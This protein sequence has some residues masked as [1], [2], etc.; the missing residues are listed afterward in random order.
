[1][2]RSRTVSEREPYRLPTQTA[3]PPRRS[4]N[5]REARLWLE[6]EVRKQL[7]IDAAA[8]LSRAIPI[9]LQERW[10]RHEASTP[11]AALSGSQLDELAREMADYHARHGTNQ[12]Y[13]DIE[14]EAKRRRGEAA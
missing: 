4:P 7:R 2:R 3:R 14:P 12:Y 9:Q 8:G 6:Q 1:M 5:F 10:E 13:L 11:L